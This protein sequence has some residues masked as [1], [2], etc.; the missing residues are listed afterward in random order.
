VIHGFAACLESHKILLVTCYSALFLCFCSL[1]AAT[2]LMWYD[3]FCTYY[4]ARLPTVRNVIDFFQQGNDVHTPAASL[5]AWG[6]LHLFG[7]GPVI[8]RMPFTIGYLV[9]SICIFIFVSSRCPA[10]YASAAMIFPALTLMFYYATE[11]RPYGIVLGLAGLALI[12][13]QSATDGRQRLLPVAGLW[14]SL[15]GAICFHYYAVFLLI[16]FGF[17]QLT[18]TWAQKRIEWPVWLALITPPLVLLAF[19]PAMH[20]AL[21]IYPKETQP[22]HLGQIQ[23]SYLLLLSI[24]NA[25]I[26]GAIIVCLLLA[27]NLSAPAESCKKIPLPEWVLV[28]TLA[29]LPLFAVPAGL[30]I[31]AFNERYI[32]AMVAGVAILFAF[33]LSRFMKGDQFAGGV[34]TLFFLAWFISKTAPEIRH[35]MYENGGLRTPLGSPLQRSWAREMD[36]PSLPLAVG[37]PGLYMQVEQYGP[38]S[39]RSRIH[40]LTDIQRARRFGS[41][42]TNEINMIQFSR[43]VPVPLRVVDFQEFVK[44][45][46]HFLACVEGTRSHWLIPALLEARAELRFR[47]QFDGVSV[48]EVNMP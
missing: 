20:A 11:L 16:P 23:S 33:A 12:C 46:P 31:G 9:F 18:R 44:S 5:I 32:L 1:L 2:K 10:V 38:D 24:S 21:S 36:D 48:F 42:P 37:G 14:L 30:I 25:P 35:Q 34:L 22:P 13:W 45:N 29:M 6:A 41:S 47:K 7:D 27:P 8:T 40:Y 15:V 43:T 28:G 26:L 39:I 3:E 19:L 17:A 4:P